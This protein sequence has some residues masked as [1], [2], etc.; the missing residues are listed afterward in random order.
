M[1][2]SLQHIV[3][4]FR[5]PVNG[6]THFFASLLAGVGVIILLLLSE[7][8]LLPLTALLLYGFSQML[9]FGSSALYHLRKTSPEGLKKLRKLDHSAIYLS[10]AGTYTPICL[11]FFTGFWQ[12][13][14]FSV[15]WSIAIAGI[16]FKLFF[17]NAPRWL[18][19][20]LYLAMGWIALAAIKEMLA[21]MPAGALLWL[22]A[23]GVFY[24]VGAV[25]YALKKPNFFN[26]KFGFHELWHVFVILGAFSHY[27]LVALF[28]APFFK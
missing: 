10:I 11:H 14:L 28:I 3:S 22:L 16:I 8:T 2:K 5:E 7:K 17:I 18:S 26:G 6:L 12:W 20:A 9:M 19:T 15:I 21:T 27:M 23:G 13:G 1:K 24:T 25:V 4:G